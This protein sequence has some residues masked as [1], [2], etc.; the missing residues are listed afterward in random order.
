MGY[1]QLWCILQSY[2]IRPTLI[3]NIYFLLIVTK[4]N[5]EAFIFLE[6]K[7]IHPKRKEIIA[8]FILVTIL[9]PRNHEQLIVEVNNSTSSYLVIKKQK[10]KMKLKIC[11]QSKFIKYHYNFCLKFIINF[12]LRLDFCC[13]LYRYKDQYYNV[14]VGGV[15]EWIF[16][17]TERSELYRH[18]RN[19]HLLLLSRRDYIKEVLLSE[20]G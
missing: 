17:K 4:I 19:V 20:R 1:N 12:N 8:N 13:I 5:L 7:Y 11:N 2:S 18:K 6:T 10:I 16:I 9:S 15:F 3:C 14:K